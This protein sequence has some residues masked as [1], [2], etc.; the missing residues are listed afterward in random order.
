MSNLLNTI[1][2]LAGSSSGSS[3]GGGG[4]GSSGT[5]G[6]GKLWLD[7]GSLD[8]AT[9]AGIETRADDR[10]SSQDH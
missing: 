1:T 3:D 5:N 4:S 9:P 7:E 10:C 8:R 2:K 6:I